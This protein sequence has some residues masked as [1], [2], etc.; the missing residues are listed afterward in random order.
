MIRYKFIKPVQWTNKLGTVLPIDFDLHNINFTNLTEEIFEELQDY[1]KN[2]KNPDYIWMKGIG[3]SSYYF[4]MKDLIKLI[5]ERYPTQKI[6]IYLNCAVFQYSK[7]RKEFIDSDFIAINLNSIDPNNFAK[8][9]KCHEC[10]NPRQILEGIKQFSSLFKG[11][12]LGIYTLLLKGINDNTRNIRNIKNFLLEVKPD[13]YSL[14]NYT[15]NG[16]EPISNEF[17]TV[18][19]E[20]LKDLPFEV[21]YMF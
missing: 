2:N 4:K 18:I 8:I 6:G 21:I 9:N 10:E 1:L 16:F 19:R 11:Q 13:H 5:K 17:K 12:Y 15:S 7:L 20:I 3:D 14:S